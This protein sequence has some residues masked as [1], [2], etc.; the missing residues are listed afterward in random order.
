M[1]EKWYCLSEIVIFIHKAIIVYKD[2][3]HKCHLAQSSQVGHIKTSFPHGKVWW[4]TWYSLPKI[5]ELLSNTYRTKS[6]AF[7]SP[8]CFCFTHP[9]S[10]PTLIAATPK[11][12]LLIKDA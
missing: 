11:K 7:F 4:D 2:I 9:G 5:T 1:A 10:Q 3:L 6:H 12:W 8:Y